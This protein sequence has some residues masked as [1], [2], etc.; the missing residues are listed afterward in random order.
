VM[1]MMAMKPPINCLAFIF[2][3]FDF[4]KKGRGRIF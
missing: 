3:K 2:N 1:P 4:N